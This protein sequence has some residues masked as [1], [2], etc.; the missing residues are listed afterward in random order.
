M[1]FVRS[2]LFMI[3]L[4][5]KRFS[6]QVVKFYAS[7]VVSAVG[8][9][10]SKGIIHRDLKIEN[11]LIAQFGYIKIIDFGIAKLVEKLKP[12]ARYSLFSI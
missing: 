7:Q 11:I 8:Y 6:E 1:P 9:L 3:F 12:K 10:H 2:E 4:K 5:Q